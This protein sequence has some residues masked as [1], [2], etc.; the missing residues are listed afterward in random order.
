MEKTKKIYS[1][2]I[3]HHNCPNLLYRLLDTIPQREDIE[4]IV[5][6][7]NSDADKVPL[8]NRNDVQLFLIPASESKGAGHA[9][10]IGL[11]HAKGKWLLFA[12]SDDYYEKN[13]IS[14]PT[15]TPKGR[16]WMRRIL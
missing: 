12:D 1:F 2:I 11:D 7:D 4:I 15:P 6:D 3:P 16:R 5:V 14:V 9:R 13:V 8:I 10:N